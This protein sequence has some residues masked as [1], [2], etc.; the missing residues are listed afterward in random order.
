M[1][2]ANENFNSAARFWPGGKYRN[3][4]AKETS[5]HLG[6]Q[7]FKEINYPQMWK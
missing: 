1:P 5:A 6:V 7:R 4:Y 2:E 3:S